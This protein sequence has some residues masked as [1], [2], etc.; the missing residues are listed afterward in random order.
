MSLFTVSASL[1]EDLRE[2]PGEVM[3]GGNEVDGKNIFLKIVVKGIHPWL[4]N[5]RVT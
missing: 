5:C 2:A 3:I 4:G 1:E